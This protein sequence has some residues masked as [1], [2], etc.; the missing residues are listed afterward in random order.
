MP[1]RADQPTPWERMTATSAGRGRFKRRPVPAE[2]L[3][4]PHTPPIDRSSCLAVVP[5]YNEAATVGGVVAA[6]HEQAPQL[7]VVVIDDGSTD[8]TAVLAENAGARVLRLPFNLGIGGAVQAG[9][10]YA[11]EHD[12]DFMV[13]VDADGQHDPGEI[14]KLFSAIGE[15]DRPDMICGSRFRTETGYIAPISRRT[16]IHLFAFLL[17]RL[18]RQPITD[19][20]SGFRLY[21]RRAIAL[22][23]RDYPHDYPEV[24]AV[25]M[26]HH[27]RLTMREVPVRMFQRGGGVSSITGSGKSFYYMV[28]VLLALFVGLGRR[29]AVPVPGE[30]APVAAEHGI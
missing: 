10:K 9:F 16:G 2:P 8:G 18:L 20:T 15:A 12:Y 11:D 7:D 13:Q 26:L 25:L 19:P 28:K 5:A 4:L 17:S 29:R 14:S 22:F 3:T 21:N 23:A 24:E 1:E 30:A 6:L 27:H